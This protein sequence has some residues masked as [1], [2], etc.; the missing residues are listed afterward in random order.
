MT[1]GKYT[2]IIVSSGNGTAHEFSIVNSEGV[3]SVTI[4]GDQNVT[5]TAS[6]ADID[7]LTSNKLTVVDSSSAT[8]TLKVGTAAGDMD[9]SA[10]AAD[11]IDLAIDNNTKAMT[12]ADGASVTIS[13]DQT[14][15][16]IDGLDAGAASNAVTVTLD[17]GATAANA[18]VDVGTSLT[19][20]DIKT[21]TVNVA[22]DPGVWNNDGF[23]ITGLTG[24][25][26]NTDVTI[27]AGANG[28]TL[29]TTANVGTGTLTINSTGAVALG[30]TDVTATSLTVT[31]T[32][33]V[34][35]T[36]LD[37]SNVAVVTTG[38]G[39]DAL[40]FDELSAGFSVATGGGNDTITITTQSTAASKT[41]S[42][43]GG[44]GSDTLSIGT[45]SFDA[46]NG[47]AFTLTG[48]ETIST[49]NG[50]TAD[51]RCGFT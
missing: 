29:V 12:V 17:D 15:T 42:I 34:T 46:N 26:D 38:D 51:G 11:A 28:V 39:G 21:A 4:T 23:L 5:V 33:A 49:A 36:A 41:Y 19:F 27:E 8:S 16:T 24:S 48:I 3:S 6:A 1:P 45:A 32:G 44:D 31:G 2:Y 47:T 30:A 13:V 40:T 10:A 14:A 50:I 18:T 9:P 43:N 35:A 22:S 37:P 7:G 25:A 20:T